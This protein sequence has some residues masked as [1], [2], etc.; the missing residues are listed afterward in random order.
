M[1]AYDIALVHAALGDADQAFQWLDRALAEPS[2]LLGNLRADPVLDPLR[3][4]PR[5][6]EAERRLR[7]PE[8]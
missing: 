5:Y 2:A 8:R 4:D 3:G 6:R 1:P 7:L